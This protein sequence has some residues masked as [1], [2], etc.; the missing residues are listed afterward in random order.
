MLNSPAL[1]RAFGALADPTRRFIVDAL[2]DGEASLSFI[3]EALPMSLAAVIKH[4]R[5][6]EASGLIHTRKDGRVRTCSLEPQA[7]RLIDQWVTQRRKFW[8][9]PSG[10]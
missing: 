2:C 5:I 7:L 10:S 6:L 4:V 1:D 9:R 8:Q 3:A